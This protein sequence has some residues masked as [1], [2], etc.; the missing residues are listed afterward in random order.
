[1]NIKI[2]KNGLKAAEDF[3]KEKGDEDI[4][5]FIGYYDGVGDG[6]FIAELLSVYENSKSEMVVGETDAKDS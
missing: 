2:D 6:N 4:K 3:I 5:A 1:M